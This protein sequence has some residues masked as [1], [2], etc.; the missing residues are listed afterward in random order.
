M[1]IKNT[2]PQR[3]QPS[4][5]IFVWNNCTF[6]WQDCELQFCSYTRRLF[7]VSINQGHYYTMLFSRELLHVLPFTFHILIK[8]YLSKLLSLDFFLKHL[9]ETISASWICVQFWFTSDSMRMLYI[10]LVFTDKSWVFLNHTC[11]HYDYNT[12]VAY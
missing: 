1:R 10:W 7:A 2:L 5:D 3:P 12:W 9:F 4:T 8:M 11:I 6:L